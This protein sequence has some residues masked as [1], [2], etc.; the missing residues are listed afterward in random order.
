[1]VLSLEYTTELLLSNQGV[2]PQYIV[3][4]YTK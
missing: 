4:I 1:M 3:L 2:T